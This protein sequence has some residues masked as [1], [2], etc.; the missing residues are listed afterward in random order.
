MLP[1]GHSPPTT[2]GNQNLGL[3]VWM[4]VMIERVIFASYGNDSIALIQWAHERKLGNTIVAYSDTGWAAPWWPERVSKAEAWVRSLGFEPARLMSEGMV[5]LVRRKKA[6][7]RGGGGKFQFCTQALKKDPAE[8]WLAEVDPSQDVVCMVGVR[9][10]ESPNRLHWPEWIEESPAHGG[11]SLWA[12][13]V[14]HSEKERDELIRRAGWAPLPFRSKECWPCVN[15]RQGEI[16]LMEPDV[17]DRVESLEDE[18]GTNG[19]GNAR[20]MFSPKRY[21]GAL[22][23]RAVVDYCQGHQDD[24]FG[25]G[26]GCDSGFCGD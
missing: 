23:I 8:R 10:E 15:A 22:G 2:T 17:I 18:M 14:R 11:R 24:L 3:F 20:V 5:D 25:S 7:P 13:L 6:W 26:F 1:V 9:R 16:A 4:C 19:N 21:G 12:P